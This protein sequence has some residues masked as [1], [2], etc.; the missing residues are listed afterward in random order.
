[1]MS[2]EKTENLIRKIAHAKWNAPANKELVAGESIDAVLRHEEDYYI[3][4]EITKND[5]LEKIR[6]DIRKLD[7]ARRYLSKDNIHSKCYMIVDGNIT[8]GMRQT[9]R[10]MKINIMNVGDFCNDYIG[11]NTY[12]SSREKRGFGSC[13]DIQTGD[14]ED[15]EY[16]PVR[17]TEYKIDDKYTLTKKDDIFITDIIKYIKNKNHI[18]LL[19]EF[20]TGKSRCLKELFFSLK[21]ECNF[22]ENFPIAINLR[23][24]TG[25]RN[26]S[27]ILRR[28][29]DDLG[30]SNK[31]DGLIKIWRNSNFTL[32]LDGFDEIVTQ[33]WSED[34]ETIK[35]IRFRSLAGVRTMIQE[36]RGAVLI[37]GREHYFSSNREMINLLG[38]NK[39]KLLII[40]C[41]EEFEESEFDDFL[42]NTQQIDMP[43]WFPRRPLIC[44][45]FAKLPKEEREKI[46]SEECGEV[47]FFHKFID[48]VCYRESLMFQQMVS[49]TIKK[50]LIRISRFT[51]SKPNDVGPITPTEIKSAFE[52]VMGAYPIDQA[53]V[54][55]QRL[56]GLGRYEAE[57]E[58]RQFADIYILDGLRS[59]DL[60]NIIKGLETNVFNEQWINPL[61]KLGTSLLA[62]AISRLGKTRVTDL[63]YKNCNKQNSIILSDIF[64]AINIKYPKESFHDITLKNG[65]INYIDIS[66]NM[67]SK[68]TFEECIFNNI[69]FGARESNDFTIKNC[70]I[71][72]AI[73]ID[74][75]QRIP[76]WV[77]DCQISEFIAL[78]TV[79]DIKNTQL[80]DNHKILLSI[81]RKTFFQPG[82]AR[83][84]DALLRGLGNIA[85]TASISKILNILI[86]E[87]IISKGIGKSGTLYKPNRKLTDR[88]KK[89]IEEKEASKD[90]LWEKVNNA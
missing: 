37:C 70:I 66:V 44:N 21:E 29:Y 67:P 31:A 77:T 25:L 72:K 85:R 68:I 16:I 73:G 40:K 26:S 86:G 19:G 87:D 39:S 69:K 79:A 27:E 90:E 18:I 65:H 59:L 8:E 51:R 4:I 30:I 56:V 74:N 84:E 9:A 33:G 14:S 83:Q 3:L 78:Q 52:D 75:P 64:S 57:S 88:M 22:L 2:W 71:Q 6:G 61:N 60:I 35:N 34:R 45:I 62:D 76:K 7:I 28:H 80:S 49:D 36:S 15:N 23:D 55:L 48:L 17:Y 43:K 24:C 89:I 32:L 12:I 5:R 13:I 82:S 46:L 11:N 47:K 1:M 42:K 53:S 41:K 81:L 20:G 50:I 54:I 58:N 63:L 10:D 38:I